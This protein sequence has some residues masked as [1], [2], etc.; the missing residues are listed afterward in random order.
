MDGVTRFLQVTDITNYG[1]GSGDG[2]GFGCGCGCGNGSG[3]GYGGGFWQ[4]RT[5]GSAGNG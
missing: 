5:T 1:D 2:S 4:H 3:S